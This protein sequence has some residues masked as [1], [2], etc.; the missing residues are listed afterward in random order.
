VVE[1]AV[2]PGCYEL[3]PI[4]GNVYS[5]F[6]DPS[7]GSVDSYGLAIAHRTDDGHGVLD[8]IR[9]VRPPF[10]PDSAVAELAALLWSYGIHQVRGD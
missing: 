9:E 8:A 3:P 1:A 7:G 2:Q 5:A 6:V 4:A 10:S